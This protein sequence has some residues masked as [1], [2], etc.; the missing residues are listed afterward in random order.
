MFIDNLIHA[1]REKNNPSVVGLDPKIDY[2][3]TFILRDAYS[4][5][6]RTMHGMAE[7]ICIYN[8]MII[9]AICDIVPIVKPQSAYYEMYGIYGVEAYAKTI[10]Y[11][12][13]KGMIVIADGKRNDIGSTAACYS[14]AYLGKVDKYRGFSPDSLT[15]T[16]YLGSDGIEPFVKDCVEYEKGIFILVKTSNKSSGQFQ[17]LVTSDGKKVYEKVAEYV[18]ELSLNN[19]GENGVYGNIGAVVGAT[20]PNEAAEL[21]KIMKNTYFLVPGYGFQGGNGESIKNCFNDDGLGAI[22]SASRSIILAHK[23]EKYRKRYSD[24]NFALAARDAAIDMKNDINKTLK[25]I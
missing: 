15:V 16:P 24:E 11:A 25:N 23:D 5:F 9:D 8:K 21:R 7:A 13:S 18:N 12:K 10:E 22:I 4:K 14:T 20:Y 17:D 2:I 6:D 19:L 1:V 3:P